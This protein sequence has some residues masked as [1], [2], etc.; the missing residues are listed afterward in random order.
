MWCIGFAD[1][2]HDIGRLLA[3]T[4]GLHSPSSYLFD[5]SDGTP[6][7]LVERLQDCHGPSPTLH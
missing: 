7:L 3:Y 5:V 2:P 6:K 4:P 1:A